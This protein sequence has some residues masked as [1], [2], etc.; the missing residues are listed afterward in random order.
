MKFYEIILY[1]TEDLK[2]KHTK[3]FYVLHIEGLKKPQIQIYIQTYI[4]ISFI[5][6]CMT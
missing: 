6:S 2:K 4:F 1:K 5:F 3:T